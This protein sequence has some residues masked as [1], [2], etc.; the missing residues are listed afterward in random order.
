MPAQAAVIEGKGFSADS[1][2]E[3][4][5]ALARALGQHGPS[6]VDVRV[7]SRAYGEV[8]AAIRGKR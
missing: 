7:D 8:L 3:L 4:D 2:D 1:A 6:I 5:T